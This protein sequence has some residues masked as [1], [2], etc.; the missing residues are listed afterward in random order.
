M[1]HLQTN[2]SPYYGQTLRPNQI[3]LLSARSISNTLHI[4]TRIHTLGDSIQYDAISYVWGTDEASVTVPCNG[5]FIRI[6]PRAYE[7]LEHLRFHRPCPWHFLW[8]DAICINQNDTDEKAI[9][10]PLMNQIY[11]KASSVIAW[12]GPVI[13]ATGIHDR[14]HPR[15][16][17]CTEMGSG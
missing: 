1:A 11:S 5:W 2:A 13:E 16:G 7:M 4:R 9:Q 6:T 12:I 15:Q 14:F 10:I 3:R 17:D 8:I